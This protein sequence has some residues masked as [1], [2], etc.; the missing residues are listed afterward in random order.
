MDTYSKFDGTS[1][2][3]PYEEIS[4][5]LKHGFDWQYIWFFCTLLVSVMHSLYTLSLGTYLNSY[6]IRKFV[7]LCYDNLCENA[8]H[9][10]LYLHEIWSD[11]NIY[12]MHFI[13][14][15]RVIQVNIK[16]FP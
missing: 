2:K 9:W 11:I 12:I 1:I 10:C 4:V 5:N 6:L 3:I 7:I 16:G 8:M 13:E 15:K 14:N